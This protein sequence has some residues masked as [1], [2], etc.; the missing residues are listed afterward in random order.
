MASVAIKT[1]A[2]E[3]KL[4]GIVQLL[5]G[6]QTPQ[7]HS[8]SSSVST[9]GVNQSEDQIQ[10]GR[11]SALNN[12]TVTSGEP[13]TLLEAAQRSGND[14]SAHELHA[15]ATPRHPT[16]TETTLGSGSASTWYSPVP[17]DYL[18]EC[19]HECEEYLEVYRSKMV[20]FFPIVVIRP[21]VTVKDLKEQRPCLWVVIRAICSKN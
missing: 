17:N 16:A 1:A 20:S 14:S 10:H 18:L 19:E 7:S 9:F 12:R 15:L 5:Q 8:L 6:S 4:D 11:G 21:Q 2:L 3:E 13:H